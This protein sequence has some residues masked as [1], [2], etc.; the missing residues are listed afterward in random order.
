[1]NFIELKNRF[2]AIPS[3][4][5]E[6]SGKQLIAIMKVLRDAPDEIAGKMMLLRILTGMPW[7]KW[8]FQKVINLEDE[9]YNVDFLLSSYPV[10]QVLK[11]YKGL[12]GP[13]SNFDNLRIGEFAFCFLL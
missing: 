7:Y 8:M 9:L 13:E 3:R 12:Y 10:K 1:M 11:K 2:Y 5:D 4:W 6:L